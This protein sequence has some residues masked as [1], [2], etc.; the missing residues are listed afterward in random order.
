M[1]AAAAAAFGPSS[2]GFV[3]VVLVMLG[4]GSWL[5]EMI[6]TSIGKGQ[7]SA[8]IRTGSL[9]AA[10]ISVVMVAWKLLNLFFNFTQGKL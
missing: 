6:T 4:V 9:I 5:A 10:I 1:G 8:M 7:I 2:P 3:I